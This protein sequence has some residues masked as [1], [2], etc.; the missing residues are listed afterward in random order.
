VGKFVFDTMVGKEIG[1]ISKVTL[2]KTDYFLEKGWK[3]KKSQTIIN[4]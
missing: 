1:T 2:D 4:E 3:R